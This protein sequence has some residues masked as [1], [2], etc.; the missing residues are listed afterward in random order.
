VAILEGLRDA[1]S[2]PQSV[3]G[4]REARTQLRDQFESTGLRGSNVERIAG[5]VVDAATDDLVNGL[6]AQGL[7]AAAR[8]YR[9]ADRMWAER[10]ATIDDNLEPILGSAASPKSGEQIVQGLKTAM[11]GNNRR[12]AGFIN[13]LP[14]E[15]Q[16][17]VRA[18]M[19]Q[20]LGR[21]TKGQ[22]DDGGEVFSLGTFLTNWNEIGERAKN[23]LFGA[24]G[25]TALNDLARYAA[26]SKE[27]QRFANFSNTGGALLNGSGIA[28][29]AE[30]AAAYATFGKTLAISY[31]AGRLLAS[32]RFARW[33]ARPP[34][35]QAGIPEHIERLAR[36][37]RAEP[38]IASDVLAIQQ[39]LADAFG[40]SPA[41]LAADERNNRS[42]VADR[43][44]SQGATANQRLQP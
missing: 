38:A 15:E 27:A 21:A 9:V 24:E 5:R 19:I 42:T 10:A 40:G 32:P 7:D 41:R 16:S 2:Q 23:T 22:Q 6:R 31:G 3:R 36:V 25:R 37:A 12:F 4:L 17:T 28:K 1:L 26:G 34:R 33:L 43:Q 30:G 13:A 8:Q 44:N 35:N 39:R 14:P 11:A 18:S 29:A 20:R